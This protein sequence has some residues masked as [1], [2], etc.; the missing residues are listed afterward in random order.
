M[1]LQPQMHG[2]FFAKVPDSNN[3]KQLS[4]NAELPYANSAKVCRFFCCIPA[5]FVLSFYLVIV[6]SL[7][8]ATML[9]IAELNLI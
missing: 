1:V 9:P 2:I 4:V 8:S 7:I 5:M 3:K 6:C